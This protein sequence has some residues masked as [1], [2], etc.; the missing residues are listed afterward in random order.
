MRTV[1]VKIRKA[2]NNLRKKHVDADFTFANKIFFQDIATWFGAE[3]VFLVSI[4]DKA[5]V[6]LR[7]TPATHQA[8]RVMHIEHEVRLPDHDFA[9]ASKHKLAPSVYVACGI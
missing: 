3:S 5:K 9:V 6:P 4:D 2:T 1:P 7:I 8:P